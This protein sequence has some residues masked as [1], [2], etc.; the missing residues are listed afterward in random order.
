MNIKSYS[1]YNF[2]VFIL[3]MN[4]SRKKNV[5]ITKN[6]GSD[7]IYTLLDEVL[8]MKESALDE[9]VDNE[10]NDSDTEFFVNDELDYKSGSVANASDILVSA[11]NVPSPSSGSPSFNCSAHSKKSQPPGIGK[12]LTNQVKKYNVTLQQ[13]YYYIFL[14]IQGQLMSLR[15]LLI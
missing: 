15:K 8:W 12:A 10:I 7:E 2:H 6:T 14:L 13:I 5:E 9:D 1:L 3:I 11:A 4:N